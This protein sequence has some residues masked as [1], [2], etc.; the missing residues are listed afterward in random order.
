MISRSETEQEISDRV[1]SGA[2]Q[3]KEEVLSRAL[4]ALREQELNEAKLRLRSDEAR[5]EFEQGGGV[6]AEEVFALMRDR[7]AS[8]A[9]KKP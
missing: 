2:Y 4:D 5:E 9:Q 3:S 6:A 7:I 1:A 8:D